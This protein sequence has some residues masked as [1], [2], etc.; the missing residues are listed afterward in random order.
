MNCWNCGVAMEPGQIFCGQCQTL[1]PP[2][3]KRDHFARLG[4]PRTFRISIDE[5]TRRHRALQRKL[6][7]DRFVHA[8]DRVRRLSLEHATLL[9]D[10]VRV[11]RDP[12]RRGGYLLAL[13]GLDPNAEDNQIRIDPMFLMEIIELREAISELDGSDAHVERGKMEHEVVG[14]FEELVDALAT[15]LEDESAP[16]ES[17]AQLVAQLKYLRRVLDELHAH[18]DD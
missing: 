11:L 13:R 6:H 7:P 5:V 9:N 4:L 8:S 10:A 17:L 1:Q 12:V 18:E 15:G 3:P 2:N 14:R 16:L